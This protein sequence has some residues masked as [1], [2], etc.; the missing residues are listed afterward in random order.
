MFKIPEKSNFL[1]RCWVT[2]RGLGVPRWAIIHAY[3]RAKIHNHLRNLLDKYK[4]TL[5]TNT[6]LIW[7]IKKI[8]E[9]IQKSG[10][11]GLVTPIGNGS[12]IKYKNNWKT[13]TSIVNSVACWLL[14]ERVL[15][16]HGGPSFTHLHKYK[17]YKTNTKTWFLCLVT[18]ASRWCWGSGSSKV[19]DHSQIS[20]TQIHKEV[21]IY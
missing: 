19:G 3:P 14:L 17:I 10:S 16:S 18:L 20:I 4:K 15:Q 6:Q 5:W 8:D 2:L 13:N 12:K 1:V 9:Q 11:P 21:Q 7:K